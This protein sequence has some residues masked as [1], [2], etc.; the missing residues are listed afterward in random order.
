MAGGGLPG[1]E[2]SHMFQTSCLLFSY[3]KEEQGTDLNIL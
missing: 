1:V 3:S 2:E